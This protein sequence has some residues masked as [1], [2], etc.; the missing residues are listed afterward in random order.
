MIYVDNVLDVIQKPIIVIDSL[1][2][3]YRL[4]EL[5]VEP[6]HY[7]GASISKFKFEDGTV[8]WYQSSND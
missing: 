3:L 8:A 5:P 7:M 1:H 2:T 4:K 6:E